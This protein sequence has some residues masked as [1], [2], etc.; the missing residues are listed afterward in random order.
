MK[1]IFIALVCAS[2]VSV[3]AYANTTQTTVIAST[4]ATDQLSPALPNPESIPAKPSTSAAQFKQASKKTSSN[5]DISLILDGLYA[6]KDGSNELPGFQLAGEAAESAEKGFSLGHTELAISSNIDDK[7]YGKMTAAIHEHD[8]ETELEVE[9]A[10]VETT[11]LGQGV[12]IRGGRMLTATSYHNSQHQHAWDFADAPLISKGLWGNSHID[13]GLRVSWVAPTDTLVEVG[14]EALTGRAFPSGEK[15]DGLGAHTVF[16]NVGGDLSESSSWQ[17]GVSHFRTKPKNR[18][19][20]SA[21]AHAHEED[22]HEEDEH[23]EEAPASF[24]GKSHTTGVSAIYKWAPNGNYKNKHVKLQ[25]EYM[26]RKE[27]GNVSHGDHS[28]LI[29][30][31]QKGFYVQ[32]VYQFQPNWRAGLRYDQVQ[33]KFSGED[34]AIEEAGLDNEGMTPKRYTASLEY[35]P[36][37]FS[38]VR[39]QYNKDESSDESDDQVMLQYTMSLGPHG[40]HSF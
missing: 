35:V 26:I 38:R 25:T 10:F 20:A 27:D 13:D 37:E 8:G 15:S 21:H 1:H 17:M 28:D 24:S 7:F 3:N 5:P 30:G 29:N 18:S 19:A 12:T 34:E 6:S 33:S 32:G 36:S 2:F 14:T 40:A 16:A 11:A 39:L 9:E 31:T 23:E 4:N 22:E